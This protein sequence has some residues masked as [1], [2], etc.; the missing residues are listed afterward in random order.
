[1]ETQGKSYKNHFGCVEMPERQTGSRQTHTHIMPD[2]DKEARKKNARADNKEVQANM[3]AG[4]GEKRD[5]KEG[6]TLED[7]RNDS[8]AHTHT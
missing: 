8:H 1:M 3:Q 5:E 6:K 2:T 4:E 7:M